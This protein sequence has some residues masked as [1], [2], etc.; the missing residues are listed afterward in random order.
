MIELGP[1]LKKRGYWCSLFSLLGIAL[2]L[3]AWKL[4]FEDINKKRVS[5]KLNYT[6]Y[7]QQVSL[8][9][10]RDSMKDSLQVATN[11]VSKIKEK[12]HFQSE[13]RNSAEIIPYVVKLLDNI[14]TKYAVKLKS[15]KPLVP[16][17]VLMLEERPFDIEISG[18]YR[19]LFEWVTEAEEVLDPM[20]IKSFQIRP[21]RASEGVEMQV[22]VVSYRLP[23]ELQ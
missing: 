10:S 11:E 16:E 5:L 21:G 23:G 19:N 17:V 14:S 1:L 2:L 22:R 13:V 7:Q 3:V 9:E 15:V 18:D 12:L 8:Q 20:A 6:A 4:Y